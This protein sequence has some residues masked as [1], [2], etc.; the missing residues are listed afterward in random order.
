MKIKCP[1]CNQEVEINIGSLM[2][3]VKSEKKARTS[4]ENG[5][6]HVKKVKKSEVAK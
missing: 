2:G 3:Q 1:N 4:A 5:K 6:K